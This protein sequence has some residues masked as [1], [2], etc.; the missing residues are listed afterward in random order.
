MLKRLMITLGVA[1][2][3]NGCSTGC[4]V[5]GRQLASFT[6]Q[7]STK[8]DVHKALG[9]PDSM[10]VGSGVN[11]E[12]RYGYTY[13]GIPFTTLPAR[14]RTTVFEFDKQGLLVKHYVRWYTLAGE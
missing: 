14:S 2:A 11:E 13:F 9:R 12:W 8:A 1:I 6:D 10:A 7:V 3:I 4:T 5:S